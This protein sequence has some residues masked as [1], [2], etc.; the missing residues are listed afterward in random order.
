MM[1]KFVRTLL[2]LQQLR[3]LILVALV[4][5]VPFHFWA[6]ESHVLQVEHM[7]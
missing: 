2:L 1:H 4:E 7:G 5:K 6:E 3:L